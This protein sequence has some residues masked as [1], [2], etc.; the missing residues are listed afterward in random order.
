MDETVT[1]IDDKRVEEIRSPWGDGRWEEGRL[2]RREAGRDQGGRDRRAASGE[3]SGY[4]G[5]AIPWPGTQSRQ[6][7]RGWSG[8]GSFRKSAWQS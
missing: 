3:P 2:W 4:V 7:L 5:R 6:R 8:L 1:S